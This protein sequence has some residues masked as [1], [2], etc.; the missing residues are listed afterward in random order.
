MLGAAFALLSAFSFSLQNVM[1][2]R[3]MAKA[4]ASAGAFITV[5]MGVPIF[6]VGA[7]ITG[8][9]LEITGLPLRSFGLLAA[10]GVIHFV[11]GRSFNYRAIAAIGA[12]RAGPIQAMTT[13]YSILIAVLFLGERVTATMG[14]GIG[15]I[16]VGPLIMVERRARRPVA[17][18]V[19]NPGTNSEPAASPTPEFE[20]RQAPGYIF[21][22]LAAVAY[23]SSP[24][25]IRA[26]LEDQSGLSVLG[27]L[28]S[29][30]AAG[31]V[32]LASLS[33]S[34]RGE[35]LRSMRPETVRA[36]IGAG[37]FVAM[38]QMFRFVALSLAPVA[39]VTSLT[40]SGNIFTLGLS[41]MV[42]RHLEFITVRVVIGVLIS[43]AG[44]IVLV[45]ANG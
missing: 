10:A 4:S 26:A 17:A 9:M 21:A 27:G 44:A 16:L 24:V 36:F 41:W 5:L 20:L 37:F 22:G 39:V 11:A 29:Y 13:P 25:F 32:M 31:L 43:V 2:R 1:A 15:M 28:I 38:A 23:G 33:L 35:L 6:V 12:S 40:R 3:G 45:V 42:N 30:T 8:Q 19:A 18:A 7:L 34:G 14:V